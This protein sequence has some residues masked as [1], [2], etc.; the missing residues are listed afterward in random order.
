MLLIDLISIRNPHKIREE[1]KVH[2]PTY[3]GLPELFS[4][5]RGQGLKMLLR[6]AK[7]HGENIATDAGFYF[8]WQVV[9]AS[10]PSYSST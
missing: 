10:T 2:R 5:R 1:S 9:R 6:S 4:G 7:R 3:M 8:G